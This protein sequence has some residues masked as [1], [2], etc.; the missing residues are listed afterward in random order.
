M[1]MKNKTPRKRRGNS[2]FLEKLS[3]SGMKEKEFE[4]VEGDVIYFIRGRLPVSKKIIKRAF[5]VRFTGKFT[6]NEPH[7]LEFLWKWLGHRSHLLMKCGNL[8]F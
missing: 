8:I 7:R 3:R 4:F 6:V 2:T 5:L 1:S